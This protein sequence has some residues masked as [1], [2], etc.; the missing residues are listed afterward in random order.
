MN[1]RSPLAR[2]GALFVACL[3]LVAPAGAT[4]SIVAVDVATGEVVV[5][6][7]T[8]LPN[9]DLQRGLPVVR[10]GLGG[11]AAQSAIDGS[12]QNRQ[13]IWD[14]LA[15]GTVPNQI[16][17]QLAQQDPAHQSRQYGIA[18]LWPGHK[19]ITFTGQFAGAAKKGVAGIDGTVRYAI[20]GNVLAGNVVIDSAQQAFLQTPGDLSQRAMAAMEAARALG[21]DG[22][23]S[24]SAFAPT[25]CGAPPPGFTKSAHVGFIVVAR[26]GD[27][28]GVCN[29]AQG[30]ANGDYY[31]DLNVVGAA[32]DPD[33][34]LQLQTLYASWRAGLAGS[35]D[36][37]LSQA[38]AGAELLPAD[39]LTTTTVDLALADV[40]GV[41]LTTGGASWT[42]APASGGPP[43][44]TVGAVQDHGDG[45]YS[46]DVTAGTTAGTES[47]VLTVD[48]G[49][50][51]VQL[52]PPVELRL[53]PPTPLFAGA[54]ELSAA[55]GG[56]VPL[57][58]DV[59]AAGADLPY[60]VLASASGTQPGF[61]LGFQTIPLVYDSLFVF[62]L[63]FPG[64]PNLPGS[65][66]VTDGSGRASAAF[67]VAP[68]EAAP[69]VGLHLDWAAVV[70]GSPEIV[71]DAVGFDVVP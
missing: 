58:L 60:F 47:L 16:L 15:A 46:F 34:V 54:T 3:V 56:S 57:T 68:G 66:G 6:S 4:W 40:D 31:L 30:C 2:L 26:M 43:L 62:T 35:P 36:H 71:T 7:A 5:A 51:P 28:D 33:P 18:T 17:A 70:F 14:A 9:F 37:I 21:G 42:V 55:A 48:D 11:A 29:A 61:P 59:G 12:G 13:L 50:G 24:C 38:T 20:Q 19:P 41:P 64:P 69:L 10:V 49:L 44:V 27:T 1:K 45:T 67:S 8:C 63:L 65:L 32:S 25:S 22:R 39:G 23:C 53:E 52:H